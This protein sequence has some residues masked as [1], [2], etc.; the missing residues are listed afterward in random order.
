MD[1]QD[2]VATSRFVDALTTA[3][4][5]RT[6]LAATPLPWHALRTPVA[7]LAGALAFTSAALGKI[8]VDVLT[9]SRT[10]ISEVAEPTVQGRGAS[11]AMPH[12]RNPVLSTLVR[13]AALQVP[14][15]A[16]AL[17]Q[18]LTAEDER[19]GGV[20]HAEWLLLRE[21]L[22]LTGGAAETVVELTAG[23]QVYPDV[24][25][26]NL[27]RTS[28]LTT[29]ERLAATLAPELG[30]RAATQAVSRLVDESLATGRPLDEVAAAH[31]EVV[32]ERGRDE[33]RALADPATYLGAA[34]ILA[35]RTPLPPSPAHQ[36]PC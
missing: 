22:R 34:E 32:G 24:M 36:T 31:P 33:L 3:F 6:G 35:G 29:S 21:C 9:L 27:A 25:A 18:C 23:L 16:G 30:K 26:T 13:S 8:A 1:T 10:E 20:W 19:S 11:S 15:L 14:S 17:T 5:R 2:P 12:K 28:A 7:D 4:A